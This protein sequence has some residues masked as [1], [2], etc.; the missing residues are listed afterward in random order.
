MMGKEKKRTESFLKR[1][2]KGV[3][4]FSFSRLPL[5]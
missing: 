4:S 3:L 2:K 5:N 1:E